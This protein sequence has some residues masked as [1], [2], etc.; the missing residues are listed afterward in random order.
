MKICRSLPGPDVLQGFFPEF[1]AGRTRAEDG[2]GQDADVGIFGDQGVKDFL[3]DPI[4]VF[5][6]WSDNHRTALSQGFKEILAAQAGQTA[7]YKRPAG[8]SVSMSELP[9]T[10]PEDDTAHFGGVIEFA[11]QAKADFCRGKMPGPAFQPVHVPGKEPDDGLR[12]AVKK[13]Q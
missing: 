13:H 11:A 4:E 10:V 5:C 1:D 7:T 3:S 9:E 8:E 12:V 2:L 6:I